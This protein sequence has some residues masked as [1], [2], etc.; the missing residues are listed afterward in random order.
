MSNDYEI[1]ARV[2]QGNVLYQLLWNIY[3]DNILHLK[4]VAHAY[5]DDCTL[6]LTCSRENQHNT[7]SHINKILQ[8]VVL[9]LW[10]KGVKLLLPMINHI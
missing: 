7:F 3:F 2:N 5:A 4:P 9:Y 10:V 6:N 1:E 8:S